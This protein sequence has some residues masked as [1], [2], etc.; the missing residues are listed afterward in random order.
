ME[1]KRW[2][3][4]L[5]KSF[6][7]KDDASFAVHFSTLRRAWERREKRRALLLCRKRQMLEEQEEEQEE[8]QKKEE[9]EGS[10]ASS[11]DEVTEM[12]NEA[13]PCE[14]DGRGARRSEKDV[15]PRARGSPIDHD[16]SKDNTG[17][18]L[19]PT[20]IGGSNA[21][22]AA[23]ATDTPAAGGSMPV[24]ARVCRGPRSP[25]SGTG[26]SGPVA[27]AMRERH[28]HS[29]AGAPLT[30]T[31]KAAQVAAARRK[32]Q[33]DVDRGVCS[34]YEQA[35]AVRLVITMGASALQVVDEVLPAPLSSACDEE[36]SSQPPV[37]GEGDSR[38]R[39]RRLEPAMS[40][41]AMERGLKR[42]LL[43]MH[44]DKTPHPAATEAFQ[45]LAPTLRLRTT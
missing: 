11:G 34:N 6:F 5:N 10:S 35:V 31:K 14:S 30:K 22:S 40:L 25:G 7:V 4:D 42:L 32:A 12:H 1:V 41:E 2:I 38:K 9:Q 17:L 26:S 33:E 8:Q 28:L 19:V 39:R 29:F 3:D 24:G 43:L 18:G 37:Q 36:S 20:S 44:P 13:S 23:P 21:D 27:G 45:K 15:N 16:C